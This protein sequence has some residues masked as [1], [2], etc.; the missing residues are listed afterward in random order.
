LF[1][2]LDNKLVTDYIG[3]MKSACLHLEI[4]KFPEDDE[5]EIEDVIPLEDDMFA[6]LLL[7]KAVQ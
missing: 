7:Y 2:Q 3:I 1:E 5:E 4:P 6:I